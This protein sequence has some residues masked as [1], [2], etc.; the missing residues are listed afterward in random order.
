MPEGNVNAE[1]AKEITRAREAKLKK[2][3]ILC[4][5]AAAVIF[6]LLSA[7]VVIA[8]VEDAVSAEE[9]VQKAGHPETYTVKEEDTWETISN[10]LGIKASELQEANP[11][12]EISEEITTSIGIT[13]TVPSSAEVYHI[14]SGDTLRDIADEKKVSLARLKNYNEDYIEEAK[15]KK[16]AEGNTG[17]P[18]IAGDELVIPPPDPVKDWIPGCSI[19]FA[20]LFVGALGLVILGFQRRADKNLWDVVKGDAGRYSISKLQMFLWTGCFIFTFF[21]VLV[22]RVLNGNGFVTELPEALLALMGISVTTFASA[23]AIVQGQ[24]PAQEISPEVAAKNEETRPTGAEESK[25]GADLILDSQ[26]NTDISRLQ[27]LAWTIIGVGLYLFEVFTLLKTT[28]GV[29]I[30]IPDVNG[31]IL[32][33]TIASS[34]GYLSKRLVW[35]KP[36]SP[37]V[38]VELVEQPEG[39]QCLF[40]YGVN[41]GLYSSDTGKNKIEIRKTE[42]DDFA[43]FNYY[44]DT[45]K[46]WTDTLL[47]GKAALGEPAL[48]AGDYIRVKVRL[49]G[50]DYP[51]TTFKVF[52]RR[53]SVHSIEP[54]EGKQGEVPVKI[55]GKNFESPKVVKLVRGS[56]EMVGTDIDRERTTA[57]EIH[58]KIQIDKQPDGKW[59]LVVVNADGGQAWLD[60]AFTVKP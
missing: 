22:S 5:I 18:L 37:V 9:L 29:G 53:P 45:A 14:K 4:Y 33:L 11:G 25:G 56:E 38:R 26:G 34:G 24:Q 35:R 43:P 7:V 57:T 28:N 50:I 44:D 47:R 3:A 21:V 58:C 48:K 55:S 17:F 30:Q 51:E 2:Q 31:T 54:N 52:A 6:G 49:G 16:D 8:L 42:D 59:S 20:A 41:F 60:D 15:E 36:K 27:L 39:K 40:L 19:G 32:A 1:K 12:I 13:L 23:K 46:D 10:T